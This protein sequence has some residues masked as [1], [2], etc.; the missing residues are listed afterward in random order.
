M[1]KVGDKNGQNGRQIDILYLFQSEYRVPLFVLYFRVKSFFSLEAIFKNFYVFGIKHFPLSVNFSWRSIKIEAPLW[2][3]RVETNPFLNV[4]PTS[5]F[6]WL[7]SFLRRHLSKIFS[8]IKRIQLI[9]INYHTLTR[10]YEIQFDQIC[11]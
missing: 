9:E 5:I 6:D 3:P 8:R 1:E 10:E 7:K 11:N 2:S 4:P